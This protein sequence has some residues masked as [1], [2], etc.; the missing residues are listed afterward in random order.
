MENWQ[1]ALPL[2]DAKAHILRAG[3]RGALSAQ[4]RCS[5]SGA[6]LGLSHGYRVGLIR[7]DAR[8]QR[9]LPEV[10]QDAIDKLAVSHTMVLS[11]LLF[12]SDLLWPDAATALLQRARLS[13][14]PTLEHLAQRPDQARFVRFAVA[15]L[16]LDVLGVEVVIYRVSLS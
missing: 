10:G 11:N 4:S 1:G 12:P 14:R 9:R 2:L 5:F 3:T 16:V 6:G 8:V 15:F 7:E 13:A